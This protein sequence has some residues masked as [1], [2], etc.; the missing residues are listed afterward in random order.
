ML[1]P[2]VTFCEDGVFHAPI[3]HRRPGMASVSPILSRIKQDL[4]R[5]LTEPAIV[6]SLPGGGSSLAGTK[7]GAGADPSPVCPSS[8]LLQHRHRSPASS[9]RTV[10]QRRR[11]LPRPHALSPSMTGRSPLVAMSGS[12]FCSRS[13]NAGP[14]AVVGEPYAAEVSSLNERINSRRRISNALRLLG[15]SDRT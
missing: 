7:A 9:G 5:Y 10:H 3:T 8:P 11:L 14:A 4:G 2:A 15:G 6:S 1:A 12:P 13:G